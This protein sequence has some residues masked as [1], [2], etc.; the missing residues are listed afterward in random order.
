MNYS[1]LRDPATN[2]LALYQARIGAVPE[3]MHKLCANNGVAGPFFQDM[4][5][6]VDCNQPIDWDNYR[7]E[8]WA[9]DSGSEVDSSDDPCGAE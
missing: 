1:S 6:A 4:Q 7:R 3:G 5:T 8:L 2:P 9:K